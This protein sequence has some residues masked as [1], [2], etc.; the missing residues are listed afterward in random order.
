MDNGILTA[1]QAAKLL[2]VNIQTIYNWA[3]DGLIGRR[4]GTGKRKSWRFTEE[5]LRN[6]VRG[7]N[8]GTIKQSATAQP[9]NGGDSGATHPSIAD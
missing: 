2:Q 5:E 1:K 8:D 9:T 4:V 3:S 6:L 7:D